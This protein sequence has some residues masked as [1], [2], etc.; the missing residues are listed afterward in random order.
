M[1]CKN[2]ISN[3]KTGNTEIAAV[4]RPA[5]NV[6]VVGLLAARVLAVVDRPFY[7]ISKPGIAFPFI[8][9]IFLIVK[10][11]TREQQVQVS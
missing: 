3:C 8:N 11:V 7:H 9:I 6:S 4:D 5:V 10:L 1:T 2:R